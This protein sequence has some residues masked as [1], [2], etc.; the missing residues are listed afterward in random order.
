[1]STEEKTTTENDSS[2][3][4]VLGGV[5]L[6]AAIAGFFLLRPKT[7]GADTTTPVATTVPVAEPTPGPITKMDCGKMYYN[8]KIGFQQFYI[9]LEGVDTVTTGTVN[10]DYSITVKNNVVATTNAT[11]GLSEEPSRG[12]STFRCNSPA[13]EL[14][15]GVPTHVE[16]KVTDPNKQSVTCKQDFLFP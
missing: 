11:S 14:A 5:V 15:K 1:M 9:S 4:Y 8:Q 6:V 3:Y 16:I 10:C 2:I 13:V 12:G 7:P